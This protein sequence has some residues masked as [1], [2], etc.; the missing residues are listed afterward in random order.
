MTSCKVHYFRIL[1]T[2]VHRNTV[3]KKMT[4][5]T[6][7]R[8]GSY[9][10][11]HPGTKNNTISTHANGFVGYILSVISAFVM[12]YTVVVDGTNL[13]RG[14][15]ATGDSTGVTK[16]CKRFVKIVNKTTDTVFVIVVKLPYGL[17]QKKFLNKLRKMNMNFSKCIFVFTSSTIRPNPDLHHTKGHD[18]FVV[19]A[20]AQLLDSQYF[21]GDKYTDAQDLINFWPNK[22]IGCA[23]YAK[24]FSMHYKVR[25]S[26]VFAGFTSDSINS[27]VS[28]K[29]V[30][31]A[32]DGK[33]YPDVGDLS[34]QMNHPACCTTD[35]GD[36]GDAGD[37]SGVQAMDAGPIY[38]AMDAVPLPR[39]MDTV[40][41]PPKDGSKL[42]GGFTNV[43]FDFTTSPK[44]IF[45][46]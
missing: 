23:V 12:G 9:R 27:L 2:G 34:N 15:T 5:R 41:L 43:T 20:L 17:S 25:F 37:S 4:D 22:W 46:R 18:D 31:F 36:A 42:S 28:N 10:T 21:S 30:L 19:L 33:G 11:A 32:R 1:S 14:V 7:Y 26:G 40:P 39:S 35:A 6:S 44:F 16:R 24:G 38:R 13:F 29:G 3:P 45:K 8:R